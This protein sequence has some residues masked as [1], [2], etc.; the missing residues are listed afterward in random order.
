[1]KKKTLIILTIFL[2]W[3]AFASI[4]IG[5][6]S[7]KGWEKTVTLPNGEVILD[8]SGEWDVLYENYGPSSRED[9]SEI[10]EVKQEGSSFVAVA[11]TDTDYITKGTE[12]LKGELDKNG[13]KKV[14]TM[15]EVGL[16]EFNSEILLKGNKIIFDEGQMLKL[17]FNRKP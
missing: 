1:M 7:D 17:T 16:F 2:L 15:T 6:T 12:I 14:Q 13:F 10:A 5:Q 11:L 3:I 4:A 9:H 8:M